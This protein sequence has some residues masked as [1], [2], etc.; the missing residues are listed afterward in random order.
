MT[1]ATAPMVSPI[2]DIASQFIVPTLL[3]SFSKRFLQWLEELSTSYS[4]KENFAL[5][6][7]FF[8]ISFGVSLRG[9]LLTWNSH[10]HKTRV[11]GL[12]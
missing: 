6:I 7:H 11:A 8:K 12:S 5:P 1:T 4:Y 10:V 3:S 9:K 2:A